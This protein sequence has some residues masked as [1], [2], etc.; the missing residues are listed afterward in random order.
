MQ[1]QRS[2]QVGTSQVALLYQRHASTIFLS[3]RRQ[4]FSV[5]DAE[6]ITLEVFL[7]PVAQED[8]L[9]HLNNTFTMPCCAVVWPICP[10]RS[11]RFCNFAS[12]VGCAPARL[13]SF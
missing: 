11:R 9:S 3:V 8:I 5:E 1:H 12:L 6:H 13:P 7:A 10:S 2:L 4:I